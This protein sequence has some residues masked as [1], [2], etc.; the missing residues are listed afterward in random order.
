[1]VYIHVT[2]DFGFFLINFDKAKLPFV[3]LQWAFKKTD[4]C[5][6]VKEMKVRGI[7]FTRR[8]SEITF[9]TSVSCL[10]KERCISSIAHFEINTWQQ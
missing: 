4:Y 1:M 2:V 6:C 9:A 10:A 7:S 3:N 8:I 5:G